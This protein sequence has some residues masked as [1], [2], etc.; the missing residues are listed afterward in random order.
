MSLPLSRHASTLAGRLSR[1][2]LPE[3]GVSFASLP[4]LET[5]SVATLDGAA[6]FLPTPA[7]ARSHWQRLLAEHAFTRPADLLQFL[8]LPLDHPALAPGLLRGFPL[9]VPQGFAALME[10]GNPDDPLFRQVWP[11]AAEARATPG[12]ATDAVGDMPRLQTG[13]VIRKYHGRA[14]VIATGACAVNCRFCFRR[15]FPYAEAR[16]AYGRWRATLAELAADDTL[17][18]VILSG[19][20]PLSLA[21]DKL[22]E[23]VAGL[24]GIAHLKRLRVHTR[25]PVV[26]PERIDARLLGWL[27][28]GRLQPVMV[29]HVNHPR[30][31][32]PAFIA[33]CQ[34]LRAAGVSLLSQSVLLNGINDTADTLVALSESL[35]GAG[36]LPYYLHLL[37]RVAGAAHFDVAEER[38]TGLLRTIAT[39]LPGYLVPRL[40]REIAGE[41]GKTPVY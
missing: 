16:G 40:V 11:A 35:F 26:L 39:R 7:P 8:E 37:D 17:S 23:L 24:D 3:S 19:G 12:Y 20:D 4:P 28:G 15:H 27:T 33:A 38:A 5:A 10:K 9:R 41:A 31:I 13:G 30:E 1:S 29:L 6:D 34:R 21:D 25:Q 32:S 14:L 18:E 2:S 36:I 22:A